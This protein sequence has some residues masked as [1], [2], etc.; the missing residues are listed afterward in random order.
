[1]TKLEIF[2]TTLRDGEQAD[3]AKFTLE[4]RVAMYNHLSNLGIHYVELGWP[5]SSKETAKSFEICRRLKKKNKAKIVAFGSTSMRE[6]PEEDANL[7]SLVNTGAEYACIVGKTLSEH[8]KKQLKCK[9]AEENFNKIRESAEFLRKNGMKVFYDAEHYFEAFLREE[10]YALETLLAAHKGGAERL[11]LCDTKGGMLPEQVIEIIGKTRESL[12]KYGNDIR[13]GV[14]FHNDSGLAVANALASIREGVVQIQGTIN[15]MGE[16]VGNLDLST[17]IP[18]LE[19]KMKIKTGIDLRKLKKVHDL[20]YNYS[21]L[22]IPSGKPFVGRTAF[23]HKGGIHVDAANKGLGYEHE[24]P[25]DFGNKTLLLLTPLGGVACVKA[26]A[27][28]FGIKL[29]KKDPEVR[30]KA[31]SLLEKVTELESRGYGVS[32][33]EAEHYLLVQRYFGSLNEI[34]DV[35]W[36]VYTERIKGKER[37][38]FTAID[39]K[40]GRRVG[41]ETEVYGGPVD[42]AYKTITDILRKDYKEVDDLRIVNYDVRIVQG[43]GE[44]SI[45]RAEITFEGKGRRFETVG[46]DANVIES[47]VEAIGK[48]FVY[49][50]H[51]Y[52]GYSQGIKGKKT[53][54]E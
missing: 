6:K 26:V 19:K 13:L 25:E 41:K 16:R 32:S 1:M 21:S 49:Y 7:I 46:V 29:D 42:A 8:A 48:A 2:D 20:A 52:N 5:L 28:K 34:F 9:N 30:K 33:I 18:V 12:L 44:E 23:A 31:L 3:G 50:L 27:E 24:R 22:E 38:K 43:K 39:K 11:V 10:D 14:H 47:S 54:G 36:K 51:R 37:S 40:T 45:V 35:D 4:G 53:T 17:F 15:G